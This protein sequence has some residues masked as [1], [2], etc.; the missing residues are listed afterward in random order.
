L[1]SLP[2]APIAGAAVLKVV[3]EVG[4]DPDPDK[5]A[6]PWVAGGL[7]C[8]AGL[9]G[10]LAVDNEAVLIAGAD[11][12]AGAAV[13]VIQALTDAR[14]AAGGGLPATGIDADAVFAELVGRADIAALAAVVWVS[15]QLDTLV[16]AGAEVGA[17]GAA[18][19]EVLYLT[20]TDQTEHHYNK[21]SERRF[22]GVLQVRG[23]CA[24]A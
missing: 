24:L 4:A 11:G 3:A 7:T 10:R 1:L 23:T 19:T 2:A 9:A 22:H 18:A 21:D 12:V 20:T 8:L 13:L 17:T 15:G 16:V 5:P 14:L 6:S